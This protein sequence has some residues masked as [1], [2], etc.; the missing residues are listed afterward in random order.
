M[1]SPGLPLPELWDVIVGFV[2][3]RADLKSAA[4][5][6]RVFTSP[7][8]RSLFENIY[9]DS[10]MVE[11]TPDIAVIEAKAA[12]LAETLR[13]S[14]HLLP[15]IH[16]LL[17]C[18]FPGGKACYETLAGIPWSQLNHL[19]IFCTPS[20]EAWVDL[21][22][23]VAL[24]S[25]RFLEM[26][27]TEECFVDVLPHCS[28]SIEKITLKASR[29]PNQHALSPSSASQDPIQSPLLV[30]PVSLPY[31]R[32]KIR[33]LRIGF[34]HPIPEYMGN[35]FDFSAL[36]TIGWGGCAGPHILV[37]FLRKYGATV[38][39]I[40]LTAGIDGDQW[41]AFDLSSYLPSVKLISSPYNSISSRLNTMLSRMSS[42]HRLQRLVL[43]ANRDVSRHEDVKT[44][45]DFEE[46]LLSDRFPQL[47][48]V[49]FVMDGYGWTR[50]YTRYTYP[51]QRSLVQAHRDLFPR[52]FEKDLLS[53]WIGQVKV[54]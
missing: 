27:S 49:E 33:E 14:P 37:E 32:P 18:V 20:P 12:R 21:Q 31:P 29:N 19:R 44:A 5:V 8:Q 40:E 36:E 54:G 28:S 41:A 42:Q 38:Q 23:L 15:Y 1:P 11:P 3:D 9:F 24:P 47:E 25:L 53:V 48:G 39:H 26:Y 34:P 17:I 43:G 13:T 46:I 6:C 16:I 45:S 51:T 7:A 52:L 50:E 22:T 2:S 35:M 30:L 10:V 4:L